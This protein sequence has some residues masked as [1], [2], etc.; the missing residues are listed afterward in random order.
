PERDIIATWAI[1][2]GA[3]ISDGLATA[4]FFT[5]PEKL[6]Q[7]FAFQYVRIHQ[8]GSVDYS[9]NFDGELFL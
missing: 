9:S 3:M 8:N 4:L 5:D 6:A 7:S 1:A 2:K